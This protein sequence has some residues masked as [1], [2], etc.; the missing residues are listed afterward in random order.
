MKNLISNET[1][2]V[3]GGINGRYECI[4]ANEASTHLNVYN[5]QKH[6]K[7]FLGSTNL[8]EYFG[9]SYEQSKYFIAIT[10]RAITAGEKIDAFNLCHAFCKNKGGIDAL[11]PE[12]FI[13]SV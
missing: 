3:N 12:I 11:I 8:I 1:N 6:M 9:D 2:R 10:S 4:C 13:Q 5:P 7:F